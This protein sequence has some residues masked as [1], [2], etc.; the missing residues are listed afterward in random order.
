MGWKS[1]PAPGIAL[2]LL[3]VVACTP[4]APPAAPARPPA[5]A[6]PAEPTPASLWQEATEP[7]VE[8]QALVEGARREGQLTFVWGATTMAGR[9]GL[10]RLADG[11]NRHYGLNL[12][13]QFTPGPSMPEMATRIAQEYLA[14]R[15]AS[16]DV[17]PGYAVHMAMALA[18]DALEPVDWLEWAENV[19]RPDQ[20]T[21]GGA[22]VTFETSTPG[23]TY[24]T[25]RV[26]P[27]EM[28]TTMQDL[29]QPQ[30]KGRIA[31]TP[32]AA[33]FDYLATDDLWGE[34]RTM[35]YLT[36]LSDQLAGLMRCTE[37]ERLVTGEFD[38]LALDCSQ[39]NALALHAQGAPI[40]FTLVADAAFVL[41][42]YVGVPRNTRHPNAARL[43]VD[44]LLSREAQDILYEENAADSHL[45]A[46]SKSAER[47]EALQRTGVKLTLVDVEFVQRQDEAEYNRRRARAQ[48]ILQKR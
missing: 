21:A 2:G 32:F 40:G 17:L 36:R 23:I 9:D 31:S 13:V 28:P 29:L 10:R 41:P 1:W 27:D 38:L 15:P 39:N 30:Y 12:D 46:G 20:V 45:V 5:A 8:E 33:N 25:S 4:A 18:A 24:N 34:Q 19:H 37:H 44:Y 16:S 43:W 7:A 47:L 48:E 3:A 35:E 14:G 6:V 42:L 11:F 26:R 22:A